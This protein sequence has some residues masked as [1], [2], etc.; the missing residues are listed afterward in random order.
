VHEQRAAKQIRPGIPGDGGGNTPRL[1]PD[2]RDGSPRSSSLAKGH[3]ADTQLRTLKGCTAGTSSSA[4][5]TYPSDPNP[6]GP[7]RWQN[8]TPSPGCLCTG[9][10]LAGP[11]GG[12]GHAALGTRGF[13]ELQLPIAAAAASS[14]T[15]RASKAELAPG[16]T[17]RALCFP[18]QPR[19]QPTSKAGKPG[20]DL[21]RGWG[22]PGHH[23]GC[24]S[25][26][27]GEAAEE[28]ST[29]R[30]KSTAPPGAH[31]GAQGRTQQHQRRASRH[32][33]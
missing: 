31:R 26:G 5:S 1:K 29:A 8:R 2:P 13:R 33:P 3:G 11:P 22:Q 20:M 24:S 28:Q 14:G 21:A 9:S 19:H 4:R 23:H 25:G 32:P 12:P 27:T 18:V 7:A 15:R 16:A 10:A 17:S 6:P 30:R